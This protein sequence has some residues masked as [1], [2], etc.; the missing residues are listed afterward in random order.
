[1][2]TMETKVITAEN[3]ASA[4]GILRSGGVCAVPTET[5]Y[6]LAA[7]G[8]DSAAVEKI[9]K[10][11]GRPE[12]KPIS[13]FVLDIRGAEKFCRD[14]PEDAYKLAEAF[15]PGPMTMIFKRRDTVGDIITCGGD[16]VGIRVPDNELTLELLHLCDFPLTGTSAN[17]SGEPSIVSFSGVMESLGGRIDACVDGGDCVGGVPSTVID[18]TGGTPRILR[19]GG[20]PRDAI[21]A[22]LKREVL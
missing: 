17:L 22:L 2:L 8:L 21:E 7:N 4:A 3:I 20:L 10:A 18:M 6:G 5:V 13:L 15:W 1:L 11:K 12:D 9:Y 14:I 19:D 16:T